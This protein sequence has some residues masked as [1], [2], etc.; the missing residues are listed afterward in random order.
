LNHFQRNLNYKSNS[1]E[2]RKIDDIDFIPYVFEFTPSNNNKRVGTLINFVIE[3]T[4][5][6]ETPGKNKHNLF[7]LKSPKIKKKLF[8]ENISEKSIIFENENEFYSKYLL[9]DRELIMDEEIIFIDID[10]KEKITQMKLLQQ[11]LQLETFTENIV[12]NNFIHQ[13]YENLKSN[14]EEEKDSDEMPTINNEFNKTI[15]NV[16]EKVKKLPMSKNE[17][18]KII[19]DVNDIFEKSKRKKYS[20]N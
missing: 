9:Y 14:K 20:H 12:P 3:K 17:N 11:K 4:P 18:E 6:K 10:K 2:K 8:E 13:I 1:P 7:T 5:K 16:R 19:R 15:N